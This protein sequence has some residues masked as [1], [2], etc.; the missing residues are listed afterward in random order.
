MLGTRLL[1]SGSSSF[2]VP[3]FEAFDITSAPEG[4][5]VWF[6]SGKAVRNG[7]ETLIGY[8][9]ESDVKAVRVLNA[10]HSVVETTTLYN[11]FLDDDH[12]TA[13]LRGPS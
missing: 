8:L 13:V 6:V 2:V 12:E 7:D 9:S 5:W 1:P 4:G 10:D 11:N 3:S